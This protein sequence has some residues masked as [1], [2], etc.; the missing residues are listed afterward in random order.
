MTRIRRLLNELPRW[1][2]SPRVQ[3]SEGRLRVLTGLGKARILFANAADS[4][5]GLG[6]RALTR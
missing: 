6:L 5:H 2:C 3:L 4:P 1:N